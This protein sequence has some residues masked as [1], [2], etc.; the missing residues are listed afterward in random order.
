MFLRP[1]QIAGK[2]KKL[3]QENASGGI[4]RPVAKMARQGVD[5]LGEPSLAE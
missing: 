3:E 5:R 2:T 4:R 1:A